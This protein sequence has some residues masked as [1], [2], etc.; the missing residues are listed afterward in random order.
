M[1]ILAVWFA[2]LVLTI[3]CAW[4]ISFLKI[5]AG[6]KIIAILTVVLT[7]WIGAFLYTFF[8]KEKIVAC[9]NRE[10]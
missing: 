8:F 2:G 7:S 3:K 1:N 6:K 4:E 10:R 5:Q 9:L